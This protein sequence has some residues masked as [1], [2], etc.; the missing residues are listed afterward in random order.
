M[1]TYQRVAP[2]VAVG[3]GL[4]STAFIAFLLLLLFVM[5]FASALSLVY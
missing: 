1:V 2:L 3:N 4:Q 5:D